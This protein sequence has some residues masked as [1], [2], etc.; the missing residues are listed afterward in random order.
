MQMKTKAGQKHGA[1]QPRCIVCNEQKDGISIKA[2]NVVGALRWLN[3]HTVKYANPT[4]PVVCRECFPKYVKKRKSYETK[5]IAYLVIGFL[6]AAFIV[7]AS[8]ANPISF[9]FG[10]GVIVLMYLLS[11]ISYMPPL[12]IPKQMLSKLNGQDKNKSDRQRGDKL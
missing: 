9:L 2:D 1:K 8:R 6:F 11:L 12:D 10:F 5:L 7:A 4:R 3:S